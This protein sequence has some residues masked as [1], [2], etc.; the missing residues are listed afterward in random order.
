[1]SKITF[2]YVGASLPGPLRRAEASI[3]D[4]YE[5]ALDLKLHNCG[6]EFSDEQ[7]RDVHL[8]L[9]SS[10]I[11]FIIH[12][13][14]QH[15]AGRIIA[16]L[17][18]SER[19]APRS[20]I[21]INC[22]PELMRCTRLGK[23]ELAKLMK[24]KVARPAGGADT[25]P[26]A[27]GKASASAANSGDARTSTLQ[28]LLRKAGGWMA[29]SMKGRPGDASIDHGR[30]GDS[31][32]KRAKKRPGGDYTRLIS[33]L[34]G[35]LKVLPAAGRLRDIKHYLY[36]YCYFLQPTPNNIRSMVLYA[37]KHYGVGGNRIRIPAPEAMPA[38]GIYHPDAQGL[39]DSFQKYKK[40]YEPAR[41]RLLDPSRTVGLLLMRTQIVSKTRGH[42]DALIRS[43]E[44]EGLSVIPAISTFMDNR[45]A[46]EEFFIAAD[47]PKPCDPVGTPRP[48]QMVA[49]RASASA[50]GCI[51][52]GS[53]I[54]QLVSLTGFSFVGGPARNDA[55]AA[56]SFLS[57][58]GTPLRSSV[59]L[60]IQTIEGWER[61]RIGLNPVQTAMQVAIPE[62]DGATEPFV[63]GGISESSADPTPIEDRC[64]KIAR[65]LARWNR[66]QTASRDDLKVALVM[67]CF[68]PNK[69][70]IGTA[71]ELDVFPSVLAIL[72]KLRDEGYSV[73]VPDSPDALREMVLDGPSGESSVT[74]TAYRMSVDEYRRQ[75]AYV[76]EVEAE[77]GAPPG[78]LNSDGR[79]LLIPGVHLGNV[80]L[81]VQPSFGYEGDPM[82]LLSAEGG[83]PHHGF[84][85]LYTFIEKV[86]RAD[87]VIHVGTH[88]ALEFM[89]GKQVGL[90][91][92]S[93]PDRLIGDLPN[94]YIYSVNN[95]SEGTIA[96]RRSYAELI[97]YLTPPIENAGLYKDLASLKEMLSGYRSSTSEAE[98]EQLF[99]AIEEQA[100]A[101]HL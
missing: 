92:A 11:V 49:H 76:D 34:P 51:R 26:A 83:S 40:W 78:H 53:R 84:M 45:D 69:G 39:F 98:R 10:E 81:G 38:G 35:L 16:A 37:I 93:W 32:Q 31:R 80:F 4:Q 12:V 46:C 62:I 52:P 15:N 63:Y 44:D 79:D 6:D 85:A 29:E 30:G 100:S 20:V 75:C 33:K 19:Q 13:T 50:S 23:L 17:A 67:F 7:W 97:S 36:L 5:L 65:R 68:P 59:S 82:R 48:G 25:R 101:L 64:R 47:G 2:L 21:S 1:M 3:N 28:S 71:A 94:I 9:S 72:S 77:W 54:S 89:P 24:A 60:D 88:G 22:M 70:N 14:N 58:L 87:V 27:S 90:S 95:P 18:E 99:K 96:K 42:Y 86:F 56:V 74:A 43:I 41:K 57:E 55:E 61:S 8:D 91:A 73:E 66:L